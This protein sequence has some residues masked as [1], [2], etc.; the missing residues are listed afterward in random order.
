MTENFLEGLKKAVETGEFNSEAAKKIIEIN[1]LA[2]D[3]INKM[4]KTDLEESINNKIKSG[5]IKTVSEEEATTYNSQYE[6]K[7]QEISIIDAENKRIAD[8]TNAAYNQLSTL[9]EI[10][11]MVKL[12]IGDMMTFVE[13]LKQKFSKEFEENNPITTNLLT[14]INEINTKY[15]N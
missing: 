2:D 3:K 10:E 14:K 13:E 1:K 4:S 5:G 7:M 11:E 12:S 9:I 8:L 15:N 6:K